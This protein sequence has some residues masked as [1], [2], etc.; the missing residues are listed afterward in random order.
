[1]MILNLPLDLVSE[2]QPHDKEFDKECLVFKTIDIVY[3]SKSQSNRAH[4][5]LAPY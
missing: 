1:M 2:N 5:I 4:S 3:K